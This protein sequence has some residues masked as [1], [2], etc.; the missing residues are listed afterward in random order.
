MAKQSRFAP[1]GWGIVMRAVDLA[2]DTETTAPLFATSPN[3]NTLYTL[4]AGT[5]LAAVPGTFSG[6]LPSGGYR[7]VALD[8]NIAS[9]TG[10]S[11]PSITFTLYRIGADGVLYSIYS[12]TAITAAGQ[13]SVSVG[14]GLATAASLGSQIQ[15]NWT[16]SGSP[17]AVTGSISLIG[18]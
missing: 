13:L 5:N 12:G 10:G 7:E 16:V 3:P 15:L 9:F 14:P 1:A 17:T 2:M 11:S 8:V 4:P 18:K 6:P